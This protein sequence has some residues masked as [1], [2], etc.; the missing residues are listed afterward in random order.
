MSTPASAP[1]GP[2][3]P[4]LRTR[5]RRSRLAHALPFLL[6]AVLIYVGFVLYP[7]AS[8]AV[9]SFFQ[10]DGISPERTFVGL[11]NFVYIF[12]K[13]PVF[14]TAF[15]NSVV[16][17]ALSL[18]VPVGLGLGMA[19]ALNRALAGKTLFRAAFYLPAALAAIAAAT[20]FRWIYNP[21]FG[22]L[23]GFLE[24]VGLEQLTNNWLG[25]SAT[26][27]LSIFVASVW[28]AAGVNMVLFLA[29]LQIVR[30]ELFEAA[31]IDG[32]GAWQLFRNVIIPALRGTFVVV[33]ALTVINSLKAYDLI[34]GMTGGGPAQSTQVLALWSVDQSFGQ[35]SFG[36]GS[37]V[38]MVLLALTLVIVVPYLLFTQRDQGD[39]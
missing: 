17:V 10:W 5:I 24:A 26:A 35:A 38:A 36:R 16:W 29:G 18:I 12:T 39:E 6:P 9:L 13:D 34:V 20:M 25:D 28:Q 27:L 22:L 19:L 33:I 30:Q 32:A 14:W 31:R 1:P 2:T 8:S 3:R 4:D 11:D 7:M 21:V 23:N 37:A 15:R